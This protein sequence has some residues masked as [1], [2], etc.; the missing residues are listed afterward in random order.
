MAMVEVDK[1]QTQLE[2]AMRRFTL[3]K[4]TLDRKIYDA[5]VDT[6]LDELECELIILIRKFPEVAKQRR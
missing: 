5:A 6:A 2:M 4:M 1:Y 3:L